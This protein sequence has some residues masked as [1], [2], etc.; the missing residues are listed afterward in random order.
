MSND[1]VAT[2]QQFIKRQIPKL[3]PERKV[4][5]LVGWVEP[6]DN[7]GFRTSTQPTKIKHL[8]GHGLK[9]RNPT[10]LIR[11][12]FVPPLTND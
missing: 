10:K 2:L 7:V 1:G 6:I 4:R 9:G 12:V 3:V 5:F 11:L 8:P